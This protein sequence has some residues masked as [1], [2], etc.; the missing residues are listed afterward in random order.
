MKDVWPLEARCSV[1]GSTDRK[2]QSEVLI[3][4]Q[5]PDSSQLSTFSCWFAI[6]HACTMSGSARHSL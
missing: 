1:V 2:D 5:F 3:L 4:L 6:P